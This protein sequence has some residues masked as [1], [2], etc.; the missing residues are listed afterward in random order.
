VLVRFAEIM[1]TSSVPRSI[2][3]TLLIVVVVVMDSSQIRRT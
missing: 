2:S 3:S 1:W